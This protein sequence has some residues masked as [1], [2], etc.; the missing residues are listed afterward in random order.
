MTK[1]E[2]STAAAN[3]AK[4]LTMH[5]AGQLRV[6]NTTSAEAHNESLTNAVTKFYDSMYE[7]VHAQ[8][9]GNQS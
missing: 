5:F 4:D 1:A 9:A 8:L 6:G 2:L 3:I 7:C